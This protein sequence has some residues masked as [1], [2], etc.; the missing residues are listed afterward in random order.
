MAMR[1]LAIV[2]ATL[3]AD[4]VLVSA[5]ACL[6]CREGGARPRAYVP[7]AL[8]P[9]AA[10]LTE[11]AHATGQ[12]EHELSAHR[13]ETAA[14]PLIAARHAGVELDPARLLELAAAA[15]A[16]GD[17][18]VAVLGGG[19]L[20]PLTPRYAVRDFARDFGAPMVVATRVGADLLGQA[21]LTIEAARGAGLHVAAVVLTAWPD[22][23]GRVL[24]D[25]RAELEALAG[26]GVHCLATDGLA[27]AA[28]LWPLDAWLEP[29]SPGSAAS[30]A[31]VA[32]EPYRE[33]EA[34]DVGDPRSTPRP[35][36]M[37]ALLEI[38][39]AE[40]PLTATRAY[41]LYNRASGGR[42]L[43]GAARTPLDSAAEWLARERRIVLTPESEI[44]WQA[45]DLLRLP[46]A[47][48]VRARALGARSLDEV[49]LDEIADLVTRLRSSRGIA[50][51]TELK[52]E[53]LRAYGLMRLTA[54]AD[55]YLGLAIVLAG[56]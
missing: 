9:Q 26:V 38:V 33:W 28:R 36:I 37:D 40:G 1:G 50:D 41:S 30:G 3:D 48:A 15:A 42:K 24:R 35:A 51:P 7:V 16:G 55:E 46:D 34:H 14:S 32:L 18:L 52:R 11:L 5:G 13:L 21:R 17:V 12:H 25:E 29:A 19:L 4:E 56:D 43:T 2:G 23:P 31:P 22:S 44:P 10:A 27:E 53:V 47:P 20:A 49:P 8:G 6:A 39:A 45:D 54:R